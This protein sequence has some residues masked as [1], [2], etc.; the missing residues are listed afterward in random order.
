MGKFALMWHGSV[1]SLGMPRKRYWFM[2]PRPNHQR[3]LPSLM[4]GRTMVV[5]R[6]LM[7]MRRMAILADNSRSAWARGKIGER[8]IQE[9]LGWPCSVQ[10][11]KPEKSVLFPTCLEGYWK[12][13]AKAVI[14][15]GSLYL[16]PVERAWCMLLGMQVEVDRCRDVLGRFIAISDLPSCI[17]RLSRIYSNGCRRREMMNLSVRKTTKTLSASRRMIDLLDRLVSPQ[18][19]QMAIASWSTCVT[20]QALTRMVGAWSSILLIGMLSR[21]RLISNLV[22][23]SSRRS[24]FRVTVMRRWKR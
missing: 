3:L 11:W 24:G 10:M 18:R 13:I 21:V 16:L 9:R 1:V 8:S 4:R 7:I 23:L 12:T 22:E 17:L 15:S 19:P 6:K 5:R 14:H 2:P 20:H